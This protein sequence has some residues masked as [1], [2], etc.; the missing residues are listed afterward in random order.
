MCSQIQRF[1]WIRTLIKYKVVDS[2]SNCTLCFTD[3]LKTNIV[4]YAYSMGAIVFSDCCRNSA[5]SYIAELQ[6]NCQSVW[7]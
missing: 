4:G 5:L 6:E 1:Q 7:K 2:Y 3:K